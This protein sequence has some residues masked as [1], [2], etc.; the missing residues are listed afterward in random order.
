M[1]VKT[2]ISRIPYPLTNVRYFHTDRGKEFDNQTIE[3]ILKT[4]KIECSLSRKGSP[5]DNAIVEVTYKSTKVEFVYPNRF[6][7]LKKLEV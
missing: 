2:A 5:N 7:T 6:D 4:F 3:M 1:L